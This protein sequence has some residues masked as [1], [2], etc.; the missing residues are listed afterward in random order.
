MDPRADTADWARL[1]RLLG[2]IHW[3]AVATAR[4][5]SRSAHDGDDLY[6]EAVLRAYHKLNGLRDEAKFRPWFFA[7]L[8]SK[9]RTWVRH[10]RRDSVSLD[11]TVGRRDEPVGE[12]GSA[13]EEK[14]RGAERVVRALGELQ[15]VQR[16]AI[17]LHELEGFS[18]EE[19][20]EMQR[21][22]QSAVKSRL[23]RGRE[24]LRRHYARMSHE[25]GASQ[26]ATMPAKAMAWSAVE[27]SHE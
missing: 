22:T 20:A 15:A 25:G 8:L 11:D 24:Q 9:H 1:I 21:V 14:R 12:D 16:E 26:S 23:A 3:Q 19:V 7:V 10:P 18:V 4:R 17:V 27:R 13:W 5:L 2:P 6:Q